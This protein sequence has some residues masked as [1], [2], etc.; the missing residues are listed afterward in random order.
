MALPKNVLY[1]GTDE[2]LP[3][4][5]PL[6]AGPL[7]MRYEAGD[8][9]YIK[10]GPY[11]I[12]RR[13]YV[14]LRDHNWGTVLPIL[15]N[16]QMDIGH[17]AFRISYDVENKQGDVD[18][19]WQG[20]ITGDA[21]GSITFTMQGQARS[22]F[23]RNR[24]GF[25]VLHP[26][27]CAGV[28]AKI[29]HMDGSVEE[30]PF[31]QTIAAQLVKDGHPWPVAPFDNMRAISYQ[32]GPN[33]RAE[34]RFEG[35]IFEMEDQRNWTDA[36]YKTY[37][38][39]LSLPFPVEVKAGA[40]ISQSIKLTLSG[41]ISTESNEAGRKGL[42]F[43]IGLGASK[44]K[45]GVG[46]G[47]ASHGQPLTE[48]ELDR[49]RAL[50]LSHLRLDLHLSDPTGKV[51]LRQATA[52]AIALDTSLEIA[53]FLTDA[54]QDELADL[55]RLLPSIKPP[56]QRWLIFH[57]NEKT[58]TA[59]W[60]NLARQYLADY[61]PSATIGAGTNLYF[62]E[63]NSKR[64]PV[65][66]L[67]LIAYSLNPQV[68][69]FD[70]ASLT[71]TLEAQAVTVE[72]ARHIAG[73]LPLAVTPITLQPRSNP[74]ATGPE[75]E[76][77]PGELPSPVDVRQMSLFGAGWTAGS[78]KYLFESDVQSLTYYETTGW[79]G[80]ME[81]E[82]GSA[83]PEKFQSIP[84]AVFPLY[85]VLADVGQFA[86][87]E[88]IP[89]TSSDSLVIDGLAIGQA[90]QMRVVVANLSAE[91]RQVTLEN[92]GNQVQV[93]YLDETNVVEAMQSPEAFQAQ[94][95]EAQATTK[96]ELTLNLLPYAVAR[97]DSES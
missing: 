47:V 31:P 69:A 26:M 18:F 84:G 89:T 75:P 68:H 96:G 50:N 97:I 12:L 49:L 23:Q 32:V 53:L 28:P 88:I 57:H 95:G 24:I 8:L 92:L 65:E 79:R 77:V 42:T 83:V 64:P 62:T 72:S 63:L 30:C 76:P 48:K 29:E 39:P 5:I 41:D 35:D 38:T 55:K 81:I 27:A 36:S 86:G 93:R 73:D 56:V 61:D 19:F 10:L 15:S 13:I 59:Q 85:H 9:R 82:T 3:E 11:E 94:P 87:G 78:L 45:P 17:D 60:V 43:S 7:T 67:D 37:G 66:A 44:P 70:N 90:G 33:L 91:S 20:L 74:N 80:V 2:P 51:K 58:T 34:I 16:L 22:T 25:C 14:A 6:R 1:Y 46:L 21:Q 54:A 71:E 52:E 4:V 40:K